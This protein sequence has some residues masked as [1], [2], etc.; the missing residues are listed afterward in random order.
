M[1][2]RTKFFIASCE[3]IL[4]AFIVMTYALLKLDDYFDGIEGSFFSKGHL[5]IVSFRLLIYL[6]PAFFMW[7]VFLFVKKTKLT[8]KD[9]Y[10]FQF[11][12]YSVV[13]LIWVLSGLDYVTSTDIFGAMDSFTIMVGLLL[14]L[15]F[16][17][18]VK[19]ESE[20]PPIFNK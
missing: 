4:F 6:L 8:I 13:G 14:S 5:V 15:I 18:N 20:V 7:V 10:R 19:I 3:I 1:K 2:K 16:K 12:A 11:I 17:Q 9:S